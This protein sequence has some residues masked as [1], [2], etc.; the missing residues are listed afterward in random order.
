MTAGS[1]HGLSAREFIGKMPMPRTPAHLGQEKDRFCDNGPRSI[2]RMLHLIWSIIIGAVVGWIAELIM[3][4]RLGFWKCAILG[5]AGSIVGGLITRLFSR[6]APGT[7]FHRAGFI[8]SILGA[9]LL[10]WAWSKWGSAVAP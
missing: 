5:I 9:V 8:M 1:W 2:T 3:G 7:G 4:L 10:L 6:P